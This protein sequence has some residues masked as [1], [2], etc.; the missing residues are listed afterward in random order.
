MP[1]YKNFGFSIVFIC[2]WL[3]AVID[4]PSKSLIIWLIVV[5]SIARRYEF[6]PLI[7]PGWFVRRTWFWKIFSQFTSLQQINKSMVHNLSITRYKVLINKLNIYILKFSI[8]NVK[9]KQM[10]LI[11][12]Q[13][14]SSLKPRNTISHHSVAS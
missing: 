4:I 5:W 9:N 3:Y 6:C 12:F 13:G 14:G 7:S 10:L 1:W 11:K 8:C 2:T